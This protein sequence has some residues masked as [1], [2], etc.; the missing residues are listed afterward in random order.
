MAQ[1]RVRKGSDNMWWVL[2]GPDFHGGIFFVPCYPY[3]EW[4]VAIRTALRC[5]EGVITRNDPRQ[6]REFL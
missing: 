6:K 4:A 2:L 1:V 3:S 5:A